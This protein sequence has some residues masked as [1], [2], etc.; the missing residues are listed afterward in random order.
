MNTHRTFETG[1]TRDIDDGKLEY[2]RYIN[3]LCDYSFAEYMKS[4]QIIWWE[5]RRWDNW[6]KWIPPE[7]LFD[8]L[9]RH[10]E[11]VKLLY[12]WYNVI[13]TKKDWH[14]ELHILKQ[15]E[16]MNLDWYDFFDIKYL[17][18]ELNAIRF[19]SEALKLNILNNAELN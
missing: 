9:V 16:K 13:E 18:Q 7:S 5:Y 8:S 19:N 10:V 2:S 1:A 12:K 3:P 6:Q 4:K 11:I 14:I 15:D 17:E